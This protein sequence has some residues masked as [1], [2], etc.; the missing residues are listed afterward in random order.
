MAPVTRTGPL[1]AD[2]LINAIREREVR[3]FVGISGAGIDVPGDERANKDR[4][5]SSLT[6]P[7]SITPTGSTRATS[8]R[9]ADLAS[10]LVDTLE[11]N[12]YPRLVP[13]VAQGS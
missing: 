1:T 11:G 4:I 10:F 12:I 3:R 7:S 9:R 5:I 6:R 13:F 2:A 8:I